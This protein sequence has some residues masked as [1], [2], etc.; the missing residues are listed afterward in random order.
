MMCDGLF[1]VIVFS[2][3]CGLYEG[4]G[5]LPDIVNEESA[6][7]WFT[8]ELANG[9]VNINA[10]KGTSAEQVCRKKLHAVVSVAPTLATARLRVMFVGNAGY[11]TRTMPFALARLVRRE[12]ASGNGT[13]RRCWWQWD[14]VASKARIP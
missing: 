12:G 5:A 9:E 1:A 3:A 2:G 13:C 10:R 14:G 6:L 8:E 4:I 7:Q 11:I